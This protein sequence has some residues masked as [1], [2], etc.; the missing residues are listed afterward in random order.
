[1]DVGL[2]PGV[3]YVASQPNGEAT[4]GGLNLPKL[5][6]QVAGRLRDSGD[7][8][9]G[10]IPQD[11]VVE[12]SDRDVEVMAE[13]LLERAHDLAAVLERLSVLD[14]EFQGERSKRHV[15]EGK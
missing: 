10:A 11:G 7:S 4:G 6:G 12:L 9:G 3:D 14:G 2:E 13:L 15:F 1:M 8:E 5:T